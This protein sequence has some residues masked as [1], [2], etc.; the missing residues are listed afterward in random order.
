MA[1][2]RAAATP[3]SADITTPRPPSTL[4]SNH[5]VPAPIILSRE[6]TESPGMS[7]T[8]A[9]PDRIGEVMFIASS[10]YVVTAFRGQNHLISPAVG[11]PSGDCGSSGRP[12]DLS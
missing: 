10:R 5:P 12:E 8:R 4:S 2:A 3:A 1:T 6:V 9:A 11:H 7:A